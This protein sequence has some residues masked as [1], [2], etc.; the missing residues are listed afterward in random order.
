MTRLSKFERGLVEEAIKVAREEGE[1]V[2]ARP[3]QSLVKVHHEMLL[4]QGFLE[5]P[6]DL[7][8]FVDAGYYDRGLK[9]VR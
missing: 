2:R 7:G 5:K 3:N 4:K 6:L 9:R 1:Y 8:R